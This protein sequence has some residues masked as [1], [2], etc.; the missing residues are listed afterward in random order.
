MLGY[1]MSLA[2]CRDRLTGS[3]AA[4]QLCDASSR[5]Q[6][7][8]VRCNTHPCP[9]KWYVGE[10]SACSATC[11]GGVRSR[12]VVCARSANDTTDTYEPGKSSEPGCV[13][14]PPRNAQPCAQHE[15]AHWIA[16]PWSGYPQSSSFK[17][18]GSL[19]RRKRER[20][21]SPLYQTWSLVSA[22]FRTRLESCIALRALTDSKLRP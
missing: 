7:S 3:D 20:P 22:K 10:W 4:E 13:S 15:C 2:V 12:R 19:K 6:A 18:L 16:G 11:G 17:Q 14:P 21:E 5:P 1:K 8:V 9:F